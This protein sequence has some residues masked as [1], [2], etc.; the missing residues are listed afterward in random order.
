[1]QTTTPVRLQPA[2]FPIV[3]EPVLP[4]RTDDGVNQGTTVDG[5]GNSGSRESLDQPSDELTDDRRLGGLS[6]AADVGQVLRKDR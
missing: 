2:W 4:E 5:N 6:G 3:L 1:M